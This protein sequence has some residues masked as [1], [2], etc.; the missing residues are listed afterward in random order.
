MADPCELSL[1][2]ARERLAPASAP[3]GPD[4]ELLAVEAGRPAHRIVELWGD[5]PFEATVGWSAGTSRP[6]DAVVSVSRGTRLGVFARTLVVR[7]RN[8]SSVENTVALA[9]S[10][11]FLISRNLRQLSG[12]GDGTFQEI[13]VPAYAETIGLHLADPASLSAARIALEDGFGIRGAIA[14]GDAQGDSG[15]PIGAAGRV[16]VLVPNGVPW[17]AVF[18]LSL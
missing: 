4:V 7:V 10:D 12:T 15:V 18:H 13:E 9:V 6:K 8:T 17:R 16:L 11:G 3:A 5:A 2:F 1:R 14:A